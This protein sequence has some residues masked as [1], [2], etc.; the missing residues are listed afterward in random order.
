[1]IEKYI[2]KKEKIEEKS[3]DGIL[4]ITIKKKEEEIVKPPK[5]IAI[6]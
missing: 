5:E 1:M 3:I 6:S 4:K 2:S